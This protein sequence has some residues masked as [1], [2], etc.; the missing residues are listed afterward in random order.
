MLCFKE[1]NYLNFDYG[2]IG[3]IKVVC[4]WR[5]GLIKFMR[6]GISWKL[7][8]S[9]SNES[10]DILDFILKNNWKFDVLF[11]G[12]FLFYIINLNVFVLMFVV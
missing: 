7:L 1:I 5:M 3:C 8:M 11:Y 4:K 9:L 6:N 2:K 10:V 12:I